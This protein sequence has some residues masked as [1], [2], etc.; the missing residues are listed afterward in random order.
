MLPFILNHRWVDPQTPKGSVLLDF[1]RTNQGLTGAKEG[2]REGDCGA[3]MVLVGKLGPHGMQYRANVSCLL[4]VAAV[5]YCHVATIEGLNQHALTPLQRIFIEE[6][7]S[8]CGFCT[9]GFLISLTAYLLN[10][11]H[12]DDDTALAYLD[13]NLCRCTGYASIRRAIRNLNQTLGKQLR[14][15][16]AG[17]QRMRGL[18]DL[19]LLPPYFAEIES[20]LQSPPPLQKSGRTTASDQGRTIRVAGGTDLFVQQPDELLHADIS[21][22]AAKARGVFIRNN[23][24]YLDAAL[25]VEDMRDHPQLQSYFPSIKSDLRLVASMPIR[26]RATIGGNIMNASPIGDVSIFLLALDAKVIIGNDRNQR[27]IALKNVFLDYKKRAIR[28]H[29]RVESVC[30]NLPCKDDLFHFE[31][32]S[33]RTYL[34]IASVNTAVFMRIKNEHIE[35]VHIAFGGVAP[36]PLYLRQTT[37]FLVGRTISAETLNEALNIMEQEISPISDVRGSASYK[38]LLARRLFWSH[39][40]Q[41]YPRLVEEEVL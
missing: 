28:D 22:V 8:Q 13:G 24:C 12:F 36:I 1:I 40:Y 37:Q 16:P 23:R 10:A 35:T 41:R 21:F 15:Q 6:H 18:I 17:Q 27:E 34:D 20:R 30:F 19:N 11:E 7:A 33:K 2:C 29:E 38:R 9:P 3:C 25:S 31:K 32:V 26:E 39:F 4:P 5:E 14:G